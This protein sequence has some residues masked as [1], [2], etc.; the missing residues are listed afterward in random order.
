MALDAKLPCKEQVKCIN[1]GPKQTFGRIY[2]LL[3]RDS[4]LSVHKLRLY[5]QILKHIWSAAMGL[6]Q[7]R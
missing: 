3:G 6:C 2:W 4:V 5:D 7:E 1:E